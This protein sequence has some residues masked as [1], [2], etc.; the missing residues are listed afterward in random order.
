[1]ART[2]FRWKLHA[3]RARRKRIPLPRAGKTASAAC[4]HD[5]GF[6]RDSDGDVSDQ[7]RGGRAHGRDG[8]GQWFW[9]SK[10]AFGQ[11]WASSAKIR[12]VDSLQHGSYDLLLTVGIC[13]TSRPRLRRTERWHGCLSRASLLALLPPLRQGGR[14]C[15]PGGPSG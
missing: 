14:S 6:E 2:A 3:R 5:N 13:Y 8:H 15:C 11:M 9:Q 4:R 12:G 10:L 1:G 7:W